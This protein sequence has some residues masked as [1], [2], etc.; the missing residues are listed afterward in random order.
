[1]GKLILAIS[2]THPESGEDQRLVDSVLEGFYFGLSLR[3]L[4]LA[5]EVTLSSMYIVDRVAEKTSQMHP[6]FKNLATSEVLEDP[7]AEKKDLVK[8]KYTQVQTEH[9]EFMTLYEGI[10]KVS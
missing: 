8:F 4:D 6:A 9:P 1:V 3:N 2:K 5:V 7:L 10:S